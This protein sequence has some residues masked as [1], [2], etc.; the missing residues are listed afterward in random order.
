[1]SA[2]SESSTAQAV[3]DHAA[4]SRY[5]DPGAH[6][7]LLADVSADITGVSEAAQ[8]VIV[9]YRASGQ[10]LPE[11]SVS[12]IHSRWL[13]VILDRDQQR[14]SGPLT[15]PR[16]PTQRVQGCCRD[17][18]LLCVGTLRQHGIPARSRIGFASYFMPDWHHDHVVPELWTGDRWRRFDPEMPEPTSAL[19]TPQDIPAGADAP[20]RT[21]AE[22]WRGYRSGALDPETFGVDESIPVIRGPWFIRNYVIL[23]VAHRFGDELLLWDG[24][25]AKDGPGP[26]QNPELID[27]I[28]ALLVAA[29]D[30]DLAAERQLL[31]RYRADDRLHPGSRVQR[32]SPHGDDV[33]IDELR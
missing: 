4:H 6:A 5:S 15:V 2:P 19:P 8:N 33:V 12:D 30:G 25:G 3:V 31:Q 7:A 29:D 18:T 28:A 17:H 9:H 24:W 11:S 1:M 27:E 32:N 26:I 10:Q 21:A 16:E 23:E 20:F 14:H 22:V 13:S